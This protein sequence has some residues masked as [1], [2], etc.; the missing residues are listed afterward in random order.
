MVELYDQ[1]ELINVLCDEEGQNMEGLTPVHIACQEKRLEILS[2]FFD[3]FEDIENKNKIANAKG[4]HKK[5]PLYF[6]CQ[7]GD[8]K[9]VNLLESNEA[10]KSSNENNT[11][12]IHV[13]ARFGHEALVKNFIEDKDK[14]D[15]FY[16]TPLNIATRYNQVGVIGFLISK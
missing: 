12:P 16:N 1:E 10:D 9:I 14:L 4:I 5:T 11:F 8:I 2:Y 6:A 13:A 3:H 15:K 7:G